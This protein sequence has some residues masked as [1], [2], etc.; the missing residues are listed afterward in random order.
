MPQ[1]R[2][3]AKMAKKLKI[4]NLPQ[5]K[6][7]TGA[8]YD[9]WAVDLVRI[10]R[11]EVAVFM[12]IDTRVA[13]ALPLFEI[14]GAKYLFECFPALLQWEVNEWCIEGYED[15]GSQIR[16]YFE[17]DSNDLYFCKTADRSITTHMN[18][19]KAMIERKAYSMGA[20]TQD[21]C[22]KSMEWWRKNLITIPSNPTGYTNPVEQWESLLVGKDVIDV[23][24]DTATSNVITFPKGRNHGQ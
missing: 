15:F 14:G 2:L 23:K 3:T 6:Q 10:M 1:F 18:Q 19:F 4:D 20:I 24:A 12:H 8:F 17:P 13:L 11:K 21:A 5:P 16:D 7:V 9:D 22:D